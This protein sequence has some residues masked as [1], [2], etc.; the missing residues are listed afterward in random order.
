MWMPALSKA[1]GLPNNRVLGEGAKF[2][3]RADFYNI[4]NKINLNIGSIDTYLGTANPDG[5]VANVNS[6]FGVIG[7]RSR[8][9]HHPTAGAFQLLT[10]N[11]VPTGAHSTRVRPSLLRI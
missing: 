11:A 7:R 9:P 10:F 2:E 4:F 3:I 8:Q 1:F 5:T 6:H